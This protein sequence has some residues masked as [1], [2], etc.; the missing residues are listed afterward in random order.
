MRTTERDKLLL[1]L[2]ITSGSADSW[3]YLGI[4]HAFVANMTGNTVLL[5]IA[6]FGMHHDVFHPLTALVFYAIGVAIGS[7]LTRNVKQDSIWDKAVTRVLFLEALLLIASAVVWLH[8]GAAPNPTTTGALLAC[9]ATA[10]GL[11]S[12]SMLSLKLPGIVTT[13][14]SGTWTI[15]VSGLV[16]MNEVQARSHE[17]PASFEERK[18]IQ[19]IFLAAY[20]L[21][22]VAAGCAF[23]YFP[24]IVGIIS[25]VP[26]LFTA[27]YGAIRG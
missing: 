20:F 21:S 19:L 14:I 11:Q 5:G 13:Y 16:R 18:L 7:F 8:T 23:R 1:V 22:A 27:A 24:A 9:V 26:V 3:I 10:I 4:G 2:A 6:T 15:L 12:G 25:A 17:S